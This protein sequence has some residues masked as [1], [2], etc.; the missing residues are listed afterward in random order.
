MNNSVSAAQI[1][2]WR[3]RI[4]FDRT[5]VASGDQVPATLQYTSGF[6]IQNYDFLKFAIK[7]EILL[8]LNAVFAILSA[9]DAR[10]GEA[11]LESIGQGRIGHGATTEVRNYEQ[12]IARMQDQAESEPGRCWIDIAA[13][14]QEAWQELDRSDDILRL[15]D[16][17]ESNYQVALAAVV[18]ETMMFKRLCAVLSFARVSTSFHDPALAESLAIYNRLMPPR[19][20]LVEQLV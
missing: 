16:N 6:P 7:Q 9:S 17:A 2:I 4:G 20:Q 1:F 14:F 8:A 15:S 19:V 10:H 5:V 3:L 11:V 13:L 18:F 12:W